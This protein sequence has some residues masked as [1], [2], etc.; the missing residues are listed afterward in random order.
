MKRCSSHM[1]SGKLKLKQQN[2]IANLCEWPKSK[3]LTTPNISKDMEQQEFPLRWKYK[4][5]QPLWSR[6]F[7][8]LFKFFLFILFIYFWL[9][10]V[11]VAACSLLIAVASLVVEH[12]PRHTGF[13][14]CGSQ[15]LENRLSSC[16]ARAWLVRSMWDL[17]KPGIELMSPALAGGFLTTE[18]P[19]KSWYSHFERQFGRSPQNWTYFYH[20][21]Q[22]FHSLILTQKSWKLMSTQILHANVF[23]SFIHNAKTWMQL[24]C[25]SVGE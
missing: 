5:V 1:S 12:G 9:C 10:W 15:A 23:S 11:F 21:I 7:C 6:L 16:W 3:T 18:P 8:N 14:S 19:G 22:Q 20:T 13:S 2:T 25:L 4:M 24:R 17:P